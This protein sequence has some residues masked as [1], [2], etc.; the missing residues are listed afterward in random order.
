[1]LPTGVLQVPSV[2]YCRLYD[3]SVAVQVPLNK[4]CAVRQT[5]SVEYD[6]FPIGIVVKFAAAGDAM[7]GN[8]PVLDRVG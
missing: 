1:M 8:A 7:Q 2:G 4:C 3:V 6:L 5:S